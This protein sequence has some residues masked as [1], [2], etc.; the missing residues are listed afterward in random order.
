LAFRHWA[1]LAEGV[2]DGA[3][4]V[5]PDGSITLT[6]YDNLGRRTSATNHMGITSQYQYDTFG[7]LTGVV[8]PPVVNPAT[9]HAVNRTTTYSYDIFGDITQITDALAHWPK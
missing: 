5:S 4:L 1:A 8:L 6:G 9:G 2:S 7:R 3:L